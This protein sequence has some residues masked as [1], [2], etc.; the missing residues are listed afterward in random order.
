[1]KITF[2]H[3]F[4]FMHTHFHLNGFAPGLVLKLRQKVTRKWARVYARIAGLLMLDHYITALPNAY[5]ASRVAFNLPRKIQI[6]SDS[7]RRVPNAMLVPISD[8]YIEWGFTMRV[9]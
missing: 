3:M 4:I 7:A 1:M 6:K 9:W 2:T 5:P 8:L